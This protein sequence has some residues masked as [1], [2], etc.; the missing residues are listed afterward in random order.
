MSDP[1]REIELKARVDDLAVAR[2]N[3]EKAGAVL[4]FEGTLRDRLY[5]T[6]DGS[7]AARDNVLRLR[8]YGP[9]SG[10]QTAHIDWKGPTSRD[11]GFKVRHELSSPVADASAFAA[12]LTKLGYVVA[13]EIDRQ[14]AQYRIGPGK[15]DAIVRFERYPRMDML[16]EVEGTPTAI[17]LAIAALGIPRTAFSSDRL[18][19]FVRSFETRTGLRAAVSD[20]EL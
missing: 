2:G 14:I 19:D 11:E 4:V 10:P 16:V 7:L 17:E 6:P 18:A 20:A 9:V 12:I 1:T 3:V 15:A 5:D 8:S 13:G